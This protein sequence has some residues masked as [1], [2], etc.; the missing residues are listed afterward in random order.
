MTASRWTLYGHA[1]AELMVEVLRR[2]GRGLTRQK[3]IFAAENI[4]NWQGKFL[5]PISLDSR[6]HLVLTSF[7]VSQILP[8]RVNHLSEWIDG[9]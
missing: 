1:V 8:G 2:S 4:N 3:A 9:R 6:N 7:R 5:P